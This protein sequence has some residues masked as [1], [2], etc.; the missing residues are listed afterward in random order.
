[1]F[2][3]GIDRLTS[4]SQSSYLTPTKICYVIFRKDQ[5]PLRLLGLLGLIM[6]LLVAD[7]V[8]TVIRSCFSVVKQVRTPADGA[9]GLDMDGEY[10]D[11]S[12]SFAYSI[13]GTDAENLPAFVEKLMDE[14]LVQET[15]K[16][17]KYNPT[18]HAPQQPPTTAAYCKEDLM[19]SICLSD[20]EEDEIVSVSKDTCKHVFHKDCLHHWLQKSCSCP[21][22]RQPLLTK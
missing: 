3:P 21:C 13:Y 7:A 18:A 5:S 11:G 22:C 4:F 8:Q 6:V 15:W 12:D 17:S 16:E 19:C 2:F 9:D 1:M 14:Q 10:D 20:F